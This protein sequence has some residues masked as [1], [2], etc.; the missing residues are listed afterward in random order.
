MRRILASKISDTAG[1]VRQIFQWPWMHHDGVQRFHAAEIMELCIGA[2]AV[3]MV[4]H[5]PGA[6][7]DLLY[8]CRHR[9]PLRRCHPM[10]CASES[11]LW[12]WVV[13]H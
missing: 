10:A 5:E 3:A 13:A 7:R 11:N 6:M 4:R 9:Q 2:Y 8:N 1:L 12:N